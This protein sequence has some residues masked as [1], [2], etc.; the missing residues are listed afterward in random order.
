VGDVVRSKGGPNRERLQQ[1]Y[2]KLFSAVRRVL[3][4]AKRFFWRDCPESEALGGFDAASRPG[5]L[6]AHEKKLGCLPRLIAGDAAFYAAK[7]EASAHD[8]GVKR[9]CIPK[10]APRK[11]RTESGSKGNPGSKKDSDGGP[12]A[13]V[14]LAFSSAG[15]D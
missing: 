4:Q 6:D 12:A 3:G 13:R 14:A 2:E 11:A 7:N 15:T 1:G 5:P 10:T 9:V 8:R